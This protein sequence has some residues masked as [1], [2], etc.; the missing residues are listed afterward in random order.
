MYNFIT[1]ATE[2]CLQVA[3]PSLE[4]LDI[5]NLDNV[6]RVW[7]NE[8]IADSFGELKSLSIGFCQKLQNVIS[9]HV[10]KRLR[11]LQNLKIEGCNSLEVVFDLELIDSKEIHD[12]PVLQLQ[13]LCLDNLKNLK[14]VWNKAPQGLLIYPNLKSVQVCHCPSLKFPFPGYVV[15]SLLQLKELDMNSRRLGKIVAHKDLAK[16]ATMFLFPE[17]ISLTNSCPKELTCFYLGL[18]T[19]AWPTLKTLEVESCESLE[20]TASELDKPIEKP[21][22]LCDKVRAQTS[23]ILS[24]V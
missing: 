4:T 14:C 11:T 9:S 16:A 19:L 21:I 15:R 8:I 2:S 17:V 3:F 20:M 12:I 18:N 10:L 7:N 23:L 6:E 22:F 1:N 13:E 5:S 24:Q